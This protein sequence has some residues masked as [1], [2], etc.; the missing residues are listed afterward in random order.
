MVKR[1]DARCPYARKCEQHHQID[2]VL[3]DPVAGRQHK[4]ISGFR[5]GA[6]GRRIRNL[7][8]AELGKLLAHATERFQQHRVTG[9]LPHRFRVRTNRT[10]SQPGKQRYDWSRSRLQRSAHPPWCARWFDPG[11]GWHR[12]AHCRQW[13]HGKCGTALLLTG[14]LVGFLISTVGG[15]SCSFRARP[16]CL[17]WPRLLWDQP[18]CR[19]ILRDW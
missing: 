6:D 15:D 5:L 17:G 4:P 10:Q 14:P 19:P 13:K 8:S 3:V 2:F 7:S 18:R 12:E 9:V 1:F 16:Q 11:S